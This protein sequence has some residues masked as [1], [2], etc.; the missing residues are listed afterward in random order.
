[1]IE[2]LWDNYLKMSGI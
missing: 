2:K 1:M